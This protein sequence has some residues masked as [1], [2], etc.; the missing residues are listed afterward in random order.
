M[1]ANVNIRC[2]RISAVVLTR[3]PGIPRHERGM[4]KNQLIFHR[5]ENRYF[6]QEVWI[7][8]VAS[9]VTPGSAERDLGKQGAEPG[10]VVLKVK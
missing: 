2:G 4:T 5:Y 1:K 9:G 10:V 3:D 7:N 6:L 8:G